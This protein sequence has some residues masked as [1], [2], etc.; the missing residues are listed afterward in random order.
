MISGIIMAAGF[1]RRFKEDKLLKLVGGVPTIERVIKAAIASSLDEII[2]I[3]RN[4]EVKKIADRYAIKAIVNEN[5]HLGQSTSMKL[6]IRNSSKEAEGYLFMV[7]DQ[8]L[9]ESWVINRIIEEFKSSDKSIIVPTYGSRRGNPSLFSA[10]LKESLLE[11]QGDTGGRGLIEA[12]EDDVGFL[13][14]EAEYLGMDVDT[15]EA[16]EKITKLL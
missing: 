4:H 14:I 1:S 12:L 16:Y 6:G 13:P 2:L 15:K 5:S 8:P 3:Y 7:G 10:S 9:V 11:I